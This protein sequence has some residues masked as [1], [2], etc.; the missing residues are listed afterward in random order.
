MEQ[1]SSNQAWGGQ[2]LKFKIAS[3]PAL[4]STA[5]Q[6][7]VYVPP[8]ATKGSKVPV[9]Y[10]LAGLTCTEDVGAQK[11]GFLRDASEQGVALVFPDTSP[12]GAKIDGEEDDYDFGTA[13]GFYLN[14]THDKWKKYYNM[15]KYIT[16]ELP[17]LL[18]QSDLPL[19]T[20][21]ASV[22]GHSMAST[23]QPRCF[24]IVINGVYTGRPCNPI[25][26]PWGKKAFAGPNGN[27]GY[28]AGGIEEGKKYDA[29][30]IIAKKKGEKLNILIDSG[31]SDDFYKKG[32][33]LPENFEKAARSAGF[34]EDQV[35]VNL[36]EGY[37]HSYWFI[38]TFGPDHIRYHAKFLKS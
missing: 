3:S 29:T 5:T 18:K 20:S 16:E 34:S 24:I 11:G 1:I 13:A 2:F 4:G 27:D 21:Q 28:L 22:F 33:L 32:Q 30:E 8:V 37:D 25:N 15:E 26:A 19:D 6:I 23:I 31:L 9:L 36:R 10:Y 14:A 35:K 7:G 12:R 17:S 38:Q